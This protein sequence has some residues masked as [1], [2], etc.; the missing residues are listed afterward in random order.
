MVQKCVNLCLGWPYSAERPLQIN[1]LCVGEKC[2]FQQVEAA[3]YALFTKHSHWYTQLCHGV[4]LCLILQWSL[5]VQLIV[6]V[7]MCVF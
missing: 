6:C 2:V 3:K 7:W 1:Q 4:V 5:Q